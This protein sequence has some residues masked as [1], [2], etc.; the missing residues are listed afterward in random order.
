MTAR[1]NTATRV[2][3][4][5]IS[6][7]HGLS[8]EIRIN[9]Y[10]VNP[11]DIAVYGPLADASGERWFE[12]EIVGRSRNQLIARIASVDDRNAAEALNGV[13]LFLLRSE[14]PETKED[15]FYHTDLIGLRAELDDGHSL[16]TV[17][18][19][20]DYGAGAMIELAG[21]AQNGLMVPFNKAVVPMIDVDG[22]RITIDPPDGLLKPL[23]EATSEENRN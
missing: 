14:L 17:R 19:V 7:P 23:K 13:K 5:T 9:S 16:G 8:G 22:G 2:C 15:E 20:H 11:D 6:S 4:G 18:A 10:M 1:G 12:I 3:V 21:G